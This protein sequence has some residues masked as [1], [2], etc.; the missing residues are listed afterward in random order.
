MTCVT[1]FGIICPDPPRRPLSGRLA[2]CRCFP[3]R[4][5][6]CA[7]TRPPTAGASTICRCS[8]TCSTVPPWCGSGDGSGRPAGRSANCIMMPGRRSMPSPASFGPS[9]GGATATGRPDERPPKTGTAGDPGRR[10]RRN[11]AVRP[12]REPQIPHGR[13]AGA[14][15]ARGR[16][17]AARGP[18]A[19]HDPGLVGLPTVRGPCPHGGP[20]GP[21]RRRA[22][23]RH[24]QEAPG[25]D[26]SRRAGAPVPARGPGPGAWH[27]RGAAPAGPWSGC[28]AVALVPHDRLAGGTRS[29]GCRQPVRPGRV[30]QGPAPCLRRRRRLQ[31]H[32]PQHGAEMAR[33][34]PAL[35]HRHLRRCRRRRGAGYRT[36]N[37]GVMHFAKGKS[38]QAYKHR[39]VD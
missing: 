11:A 14:V 27:P 36:E 31:R 18:H 8:P 23:V 20:G 15:P 25:R 17:G 29:H 35:H 39:H 4:R 1:L 38:Q 24:A 9:A 2:S 30:P 10:P 16:A 3:K 7:W 28:P 12:R 19:V 33:S 13:R 34:R 26:L 6:W 5:R 22:G 21:R 37:V 32:P